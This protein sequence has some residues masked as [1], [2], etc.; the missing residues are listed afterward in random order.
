MGDA[1][2]PIMS[3]DVTAQLDVKE[4]VRI[5]LDY[6]RELFGNPFMD[7]SLEEVQKAK[8]GQW[9]VTVGY[10]MARN[11]SAGLQPI[12]NYPRMYK[13]ILVDSNTREVASMKVAKF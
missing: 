6:F 7:L 11:T 13:L 12:S 2:V 4:A 8:D 5:A 9:A 3:G 10:V 1:A